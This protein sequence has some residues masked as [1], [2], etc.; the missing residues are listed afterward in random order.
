MERYAFL[1]CLLPA[2]GTAQTFIPTNPASQ[3][4]RKW[5]Q[6]HERA[7]VDEFIS[8]LSIVNIAADR[9]NIQRNAEAIA[10]MMEKRGITAKLV[11]VPGGNPIVFGEIKTAGATR[12]IVF[13]AHYD[14]Q[15]LDPKEWTTPPFQPVLR[16]GT[17]EREGALIPLPDPGNSFSPE[18][19][20]YARSSGDDKAPIIAIF[21]AL[22]A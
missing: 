11:S 15:P 19:R 14:G 21:A 6:Q 1:L 8:L 4:G 20:I 3:A 10:G 12:T 7:I 16:N 5:R 22:D 2:G 13:Y 17:I 18:W 9:A